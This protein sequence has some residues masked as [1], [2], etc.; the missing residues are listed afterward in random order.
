VSALASLRRFVAGSPARGDAAGG[1]AATART[2]GTD[3]SACQLC[4]EPVG[5][6][7]RHLVDLSQRRLVCA[8]RACA[9]L[10][11]E[12]AEAPMARRYR[13]V[14]ERVCVD[15]RSSPS[16]DAWQQLGVPVGLSFFLHDSSTSRWVACFPSPAGPI[17]AEIEPE[18]WHAFARESPLCRVVAPDVEALLVRSERGGPRECWVVPIASCYELVGLV[19]RHWRGFDGGERLRVEL[20]AFCAALRERAERV[21]PPT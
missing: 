9:L 17:E 8:C 18:R 4:A 14:P 1:D 6:A 16:E 5:E 7:H 21:E 19:R 2:A 20:D 12:P 13:T 15:P 11:V 3:S 10:F